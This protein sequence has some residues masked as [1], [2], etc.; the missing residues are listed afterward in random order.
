MASAQNPTTQKLAL[1]TLLAFKSSQFPLHYPAPQQFPDLQ[2]FLHLLFDAMN[3]TNVNQVLVAETQI[4]ENL[5]AGPPMTNPTGSNHHPTAMNAT[6]ATDATPATNVIPAPV[7]SPAPT[8][9][10]TATSPVAPRQPSRLVSRNWLHLDA[11]NHPPSGP[12]V[13]PSCRCQPG[14]WDWGLAKRE[15]TVLAGATRPYLAEAITQN[16]NQGLV[17]WQAVISSDR[18]YGSSKKAFIKTKE[19]WLAF[20]KAAKLSSTRVISIR[21][22]QQDPCLIARK[23]TMDAEADAMLIMLNGTQEECAPLEQTRARLTANMT[24]RRDR[25]AWQR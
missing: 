12:S 1:P 7:V 13:Y 2:Q 10:P 16:D 6:P 18:T 19:D 22:Y 20:A 21:I 4:V 23:E 11:V 3:P 5:N 24:Q 25:T 14:N 8:S 9:N 17:T 15:L